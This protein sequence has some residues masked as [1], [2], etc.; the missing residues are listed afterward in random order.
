[1]T[2]RSDEILIKN[3]ESLYNSIFIFDCYSAS[4]IAKYEFI[5]NKLEKRG[6]TVREEK[7]IIIEKDEDKEE[8]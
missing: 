3:A 2:N 6:Y 8:D 5:L 7:R 4:D 1:M